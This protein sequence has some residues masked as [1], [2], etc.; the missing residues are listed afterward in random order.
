[1]EDYLNA[2]HQGRPFLDYRPDIGR[3][4][5]PSAVTGEGLSR[6]IRGGLR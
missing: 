3:H 5:F 1:M 4:V 2:A 6:R